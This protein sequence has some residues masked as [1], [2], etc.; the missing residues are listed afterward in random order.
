MGN[1]KS[2]QPSYLIDGIS[3][4]IQVIVVLVM[5]AFILQTLWYYKNKTEHEEDIWKVLLI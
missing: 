4:V 5:S 3:M 2:R 1:E